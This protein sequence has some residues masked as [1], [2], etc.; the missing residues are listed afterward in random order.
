MGVAKH[1]LAFDSL[2]RARTGV[3]KCLLAFD[4]LW[5]SLVIVT[6]IVCVRELCYHRSTILLI[7]RT[8]P[9][10]GKLLITFNARNGM[11]I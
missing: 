9:F 11:L 5:A 2:C 3:R 4:S 8:S 7:V 10:P 6:L 1:V